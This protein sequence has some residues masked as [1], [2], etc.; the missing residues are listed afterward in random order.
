[1]DEDDIIIPEGEPLKA[2]FE[3]YYFI[4]YLDLEVERAGSLHSAIRAFRDHLSEDRR[5]VVSAFLVHV[6][7]LAPNDCV[8]LVTEVDDAPVIQWSDSADGE[9][10]YQTYLEIWNTDSA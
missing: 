8:M 1:M 4:I 5:A 7:T 3:W 10:I 9:H 6:S 2:P